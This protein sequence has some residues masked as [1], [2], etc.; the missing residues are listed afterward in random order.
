MM[1]KI[2]K[3]VTT[4]RRRQTGFDESGGARAKWRAGEH[5]RRIA[6]HG[7]PSESADDDVGRARAVGGAGVAPQRPARASEHA[8]ARPKGE[9]GRPSRRRPMRRARAATLPNQSGP[10][11]FGGEV[12]RGADHGGA[13]H[14]R[15][16]R[17]RLATAA[18]HHSDRP[19]RNLSIGADRGPPSRISRVFR[20]LN[21][22]VR[23]RF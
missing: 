9:P 8:S 19:A 10:V 2:S 6:A 13:D 14:G 15:R 12:M 16:G 21:L 7:P 4:R 3:C 18:V 23:G 17:P 20:R 22:I 11:R 1:S 5:R